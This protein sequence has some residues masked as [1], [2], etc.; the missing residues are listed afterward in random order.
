M[1]DRRHDGVRRPGA[2]RADRSEAQARARRRKLPDLHD[3]LGVGHFGFAAGATVPRLEALALPPFFEYG[4]LAARAS[5]RHLAY[6]E[7]HGLL[8]CTSLQSSYQA[9]AQA[10]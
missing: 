2:L 1:R 4:R 10:G 8:P 7:F 5:G 6:T 3:K 9:W